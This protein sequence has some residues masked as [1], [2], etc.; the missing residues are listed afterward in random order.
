VP[1]PVLAVGDGALG[2]WGALTQ[3]YDPREQRCRVHKLAN[4]LD[5]LPKRLQPR[6]KALLHEVMLVPTRKTAKEAIRGF[7][8]EFEAKYPKAVACLT[9]D[10]EPLL[11]LCDFPAQH[12]IHRRTTN[13]IESPFATVKMG[14][15]QTKGAGSRNAALAFAYGLALAAEDHW[16]RLNAPELLPLVEARVR[17]KDGL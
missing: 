7:A 2:F 8:S 10:Q 16:R 1:S 3:V 14:T 12:W 15:G 5:K 17:F 6:A 9:E 13:P 4:H 11:T